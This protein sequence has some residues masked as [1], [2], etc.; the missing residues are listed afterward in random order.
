MDTNK[1]FVLKLD[2]TNS[3]ADGRSSV[4]GISWR[5][6]RIILMLSPSLSP[7]SKLAKILNKNKSKEQAFFFVRLEVL[8]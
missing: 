3:E 6:L 1:A 7:A 4:A 2:A 8:K 5:F